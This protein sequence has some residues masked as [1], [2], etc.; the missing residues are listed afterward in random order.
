[1]SE[2]DRSKLPFKWS[3]TVA[4][5]IEKSWDQKYGENIVRE[6][7][8]DS[9]YNYRED[10]EAKCKLLNEECLDCPERKANK[11]KYTCIAYGVTVHIKEYV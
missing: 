10:Q 8:I 4:Y 5:L 11:T 2:E 3:H 7:K 1:M 9:G 6:S